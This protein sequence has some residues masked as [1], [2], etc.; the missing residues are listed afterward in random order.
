MIR[1]AVLPLL[2]ASLLAGEESAVDW[3][4]ARKFWSF[5]SPT[6]GTLP[7]VERADWP[8]TRVDHFVLAELE[9]RELTP[10]ARA[11]KRHLIRRLF[12][13]LN[14]LPP[15]SPEMEDFLKQDVEQVVESL[16]GRRAFGERLASLWLNLSR[17]AEDQAHQVG[18]N[19]TLAYP[20]AYR[21]R[22]W[23]IEAF[24][25]DLP[26]DEFIR[27]QLAVDLLEPDNKQDLAALGY[28]G[29]GHKYYSRGRLEVQAEEW[30]EKVDTVSRSLLGLTVACAQCHD[31]K[32]DPITMKDYYG[33]AGVFASIKMVNKSADGVY[34]KKGA[35]ADKMHQDT[36]H[37]I[38]DNEA[39]TDL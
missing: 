29:L 13:D 35:K 31:H 14:G 39:A 18:S 30:A 24:N 15:A 34:E 7:T 17:Y 26:Y 21:Y 22:A 11:T 4:K 9:Q 3:G 10:S 37:L 2:S 20:N 28:M 5:Q 12:F 25:S 33:L 6:A 27:K 16:L 36:L 1:F 8:Q 38:E 23:V 19:T 32:Y